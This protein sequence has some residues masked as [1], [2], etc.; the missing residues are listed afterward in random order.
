MLKEMYDRLLYYLGAVA[1]WLVGQFLS[2]QELIIVTVLV[3]CILGWA[4]Y[5]YIRRIRKEFK[6][7]LIL[8][9]EGMKG[10][11][12]LEHM[13][14]AERKAWKD[15]IVAEAVKNAL[16]D[17]FLHNKL[18]IADVNYY[19]SLVGQNLR[20]PHIVSM[21]QQVLKWQIRQRLGLGKVLYKKVPFPDAGNTIGTKPE[22]SPVPG[23]AMVKP[24]LTLLQKVSAAK[25]A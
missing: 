4:M 7:Q 6:Q 23:D 17:L 22:V 16:D 5:L 15:K 21:G 14:H 19:C 18:T 2:Y 8:Y 9:E 13:N 12:M 10:N 11:R 20:L 24:K 25:A 1:E 3:S